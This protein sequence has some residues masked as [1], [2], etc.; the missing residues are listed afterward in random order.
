[1]EERAAASAPYSVY[2]LRAGARPKS[3]ATA[4]GG[5][6]AAE[7]VAAWVCT[8]FFAPALA[9]EMPVVKARVHRA[10]LFVR[11]RLSEHFELGRTGSN[12]TNKTLDR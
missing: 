2:L 4:L 3:S 5:A 12:S 6:A 10:R 11:R 7:L 9:V 1:M 8:L